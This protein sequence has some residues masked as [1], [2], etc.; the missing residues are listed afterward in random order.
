M[1]WFGRKK[2]VEDQRD[3]YLDLLTIRDADRLRSLARTVLAENGFEAE[4]RGDH[5]RTADGRT[6]GLDNLMRKARAGGASAWD[7]IV[8]EHFAAML[9]P[10]DEEPDE[11]EMRER[12][13]ARLWD[14]TATDERMTFDY[15]L[16]WQPGVAE[17][18][19]VDHPDRVSILGDGSARDLAPLGP[20]YDRARRNLFRELTDNAELR[21]E[22]VEHDG[23]R[24]QCALSDSVYTASGALLLPDV[25]PRWV[26][27]IDLS[28][29]V[30]FGVPF[31]NQLAFAA[32]SDAASALGGLMLLPVFTANGYSDG[33]GP[34]SPNV[35]YW[36]DGA[37]AQISSIADD[38]LNVT[39][40]PELLEIINGE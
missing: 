38:A 4:V 39:P 6:F 19:T 1:G 11:A 5:V 27:G 16:E 29:G 18:L 40:P 8:R 26:P 17:L 36:R 15:A 23:H 34:V 2:S 9:R 25:L 35:Y 20:W 31:R 37:V 3:P 24:I 30:L 28:G 33:V 12:I 14:V 22:T 13:I 7:G 32:C 21:V 10:F